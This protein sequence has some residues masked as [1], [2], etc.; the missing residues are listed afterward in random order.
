VQEGETGN[1]FFIVIDGSADVTQKMK[2]GSIKKVGQLG[3]R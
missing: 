3:P 2:N 1:E